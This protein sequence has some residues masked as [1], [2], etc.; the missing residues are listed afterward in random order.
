MDQL[1]EILPKLG[2]PGLI[3]GALIYTVHI[4]LKKMS[5]EGA[6]ERAEHANEID[7]VLA[8][9]KETV[10]LILASHERERQ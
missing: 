8:A 10:A 3:A 4:M 1:I 9:H 5:E 6:S 2:A 7:R